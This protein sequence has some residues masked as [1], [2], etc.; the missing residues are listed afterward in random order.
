MPKSFERFQLPGAPTCRVA[1]TKGLFEKLAV[2]G[3][4]PNKKKYNCVVLVPKNDEAK[5]KVLNE[6][7]MEAFEGLKALGSGFKSPKAIDIKNRGVIDGDEWADMKEGREEFRG[8]MMVKCGSPHVR[9]IVT[10]AQKRV[11]LNGVPWPDRVIPIEQQS[12]EEFNSGDYAVCVLSFWAYKE[13]TFEGISANPLAFVKRGDGER[14]GGASSN[15][16][17]YV[18]DSAFAEYE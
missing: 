2:K 16:E 17:D 6:K 4:D 18:D 11:I 3:G 1:Y 9:P 13:S 5:M 8:Y 7:Y 14:I 10:D 15:V 12:D